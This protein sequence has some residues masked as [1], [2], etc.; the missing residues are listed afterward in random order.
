M[1]DFK[2]GDPDSFE[3]Q[4]GFGENQ[5]V[6]HRGVTADIGIDTIILKECE[7]VDRDRA[8]WQLLNLTTIHTSNDDEGKNNA[9][10]FDDPF[11]VD[12]PYFSGE[13]T[14]GYSDPDLADFDQGLTGAAAIILNKAIKSNLNIGKFPPYGD[15]IVDRFDVAFEEIHFPLA[16]N[17]DPLSVSGDVT[18]FET[19]VQEQGVDEADIIKADANY[20]Y[21]SYGNYIVIWDKYGKKQEQLKMPDYPTSNRDDG[22]ASWR[23]KPNIESLLLTSGYLVVFVSGYGYTLKENLTR[24]A[25]LFNYLNTQIRIY[26]TTDLA[27]KSVKNINGR[28]V[29]A[30]MVGKY[31]HAV[32]NSGINTH[33]YLVESMDRNQYFQGLSDEEYYVAAQKQA[34]ERNIPDFIQNMREELSATEDFPTFL[35]INRWQKDIPED[36]S[37]LDVSFSEGVANHVVWVA[38]FDATSLSENTNEEELSVQTSSFFTPYA[39][40]HMYG[41][42]NQ[43]ILA[44]QGWN[45][46]AVVVGQ[47]QS[48]CLVGLVLDGASTMFT[49][50]GIVAGHLLNSFALDIHGNELRVATTIRKRWRWNPFLTNNIILE[51]EPIEAMLP[52]KVNTEEFAN[53]GTETEDSTAYDIKPILSD[54]R[55]DNEFL[56][57][58]STENYVIILKLQGNEKGDME[59][60][61]RV[62]IG[63]PHESITAIRFFD[64][65]AYVVTFERTDP[66]YVIGLV[67]GI[68]KELGKFKINGFSSYL[69]PIANDNRLLIGIGQNAT[70]EGI[71]SGLMVTIFNATVREN[72][73][74]I[75]SHTIKNEDNRY[76]SSDAEWEHK[77]FR[78]IDGKLVLPLNEHYRI[79]DQ[80]T[81]RTTYDNF[82]GFVIFNVTTNSIVEQFRVSHKSHRCYYC[83]GQFPP[84]SFTYDGNLMTV[85][86]SVVSSADLDSGK[87]IWRMD[88]LIDGENSA[89]CPYNFS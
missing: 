89:C 43:I 83:G 17:S 62:K 84:R 57:E 24:P 19:N 56:E 1:F 54:P 20:I 35:Q 29:D 7:K 86:G 22:F 67:D 65:F 30:R 44:T 72:P 70:E 53:I 21:A 81:G 42:K 5:C 63:D 9:I 14:E 79:K 82:K 33:R 4:I 3:G 60:M 49:S 50:V 27:L 68:P 8:K 85:K 48:T 80:L 23:R 61:G 78:Y 46:N 40:L 31:I 41:T 37:L 15:E 39:W 12:L 36:E 59:E 64:T 2:D 87:E 76:S 75:V 45:W 73:V 69:H 52:R 13:I 11:Y 71:V 26:S 55:Q 51:T 16:E 77:S 88:I 18:D 47:E 28:F 74:A 6:V 38:S 25:V 32:T 66:F 34:R 58:S 10:E